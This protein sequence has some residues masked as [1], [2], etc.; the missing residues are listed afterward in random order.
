MPIPKP[1][2][3]ILQLGHPLARGLLCAF[4]LHEGSGGRSHDLL[5]ARTG[6]WSGSGSHWIGSQHGWAASFNGTDDYLEW[7]PSIALTTSWTA[8]CWFRCTSGSSV[9]RPLV[10]WSTPSSSNRYGIFLGT[11]GIP[12]IG[13]GTD[14]HTCGSTDCR[15]SQWRLLVGS[16]DGT[17]RALHLN[18]VLQA[19][20]TSSSLGLTLANVL[21]IGR[22]AHTGSFWFAGQ[23]AG[24]LIYNRV[25]SANEIRQLYADPWGMY[26]PTAFEPAWRK[27]RHN[28]LRPTSPVFGST[29]IGSA[30]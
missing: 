23:I 11:N 24:A 6:A 16:F 28:I 22:F 25:L 13:Y 14:G 5:R 30:A 15:D 26:Q 7:T 21:R 29:T 3:P 17:N 2:F 10:E 18:G 9:F 19:N 12:S 1:S 27:R 8:A 20:N 4:P